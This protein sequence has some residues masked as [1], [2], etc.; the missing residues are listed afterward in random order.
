MVACRDM[1]PQKKAKGII[2]NEDTGTS[3]GQ[4]TKISIN[5]WERQS[6][7]KGISVKANF[8][9]DGIYA[10]LLTTSDSEGE[11]YEPQIVDFMDDELIATQRAELRSERMNNPS[12]I[13]NPLPTATSPPIVEQYV[14]PTSPIQGPPPKSM[15]RLK[16]ERLRTIIEKKSLSNDGVISRYQKILRCLKGEQQH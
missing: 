14:V 8:Y 5:Q 4:T 2:I 16:T 11:H 7:I 15:N 10:T 3:R 9:S 12:R 1:R 6:K 13:K